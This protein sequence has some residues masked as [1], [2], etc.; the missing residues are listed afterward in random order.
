[1]QVMTIVFIGAILA[2]CDYI[3][4]DQQRV[5]PRYSFYLCF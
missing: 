5:I 2:Y 4:N 1:M 3:D